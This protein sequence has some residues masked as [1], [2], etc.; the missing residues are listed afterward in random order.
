L[1]DDKDD[2]FY[3]QNQVVKYEQNVLDLESVDKVK[4]HLKTCHACVNLYNWTSMLGK[5][6]EL[7][8]KQEKRQDLPNIIFEHIK[9]VELPKTFFNYIYKS[10][11]TRVGLIL[12]LIIFVFASI[13]Y[14]SLYEN[15]ILKIASYK[16]DIINKDIQIAVVEESDEEFDEEYD[17]EELTTVPEPMPVVAKNTEQDLKKE[18]LFVENFL[19]SLSPEAKVNDSLSK[20]ELI[21]ELLKIDLTKKKEI[22]KAAPISVV[23]NTV[24]PITGSRVVA[25]QVKV[26]E[27]K[28]SPMLYK[29]VGSSSD[30]PSLDAKLKAILIKYKATKAGNVNFG[31]L[32]NGGSYYHF[33]SD[34]DNH[35]QL[36]AE[37]T[38]LVN[39]KVM[40]EKET[41]PA[42]NGKVRSVIWLGRN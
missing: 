42:I 9:K 39:F 31:D 37:I 24:T 33:Y 4:K 40:K 5:T 38:E 6:L 41:R 19:A 29:F 27:V 18:E 32:S 35:E 14:Q 15:T 2:C 8:F 26:S 23:V 30:W 1:L 22:V 3:I 21:A 12:T 16:L 28:M 17:E 10:Y 20:E 13:N 7:G 36:V 25:E 11:I 34:M